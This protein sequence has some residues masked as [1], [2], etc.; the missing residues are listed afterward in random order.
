M[1]PINYSGAKIYKG[2]VFR[3]SFRLSRAG[4]YVQPDDVIFTLSTA[5]GGTEVFETSYAESPTYISVDDD[6][7]WTVE[8]PA[9][10]TANIEDAEVYMQVDIIEDSARERWITG[11]AR[12]LQN[13]TS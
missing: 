9:S 10:Q 8:I 7:I 4:E 1:Q 2:A 12:V 11:N 13:A 6:Q 3:F 5:P